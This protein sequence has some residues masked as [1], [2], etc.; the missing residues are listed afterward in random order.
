MFSP[1]ATIFNLVVKSKKL[2]W[3][4]GQS[5]HGK[6]QSVLHLASSSITPIYRFS[7][8]ALSGGRGLNKPG[9]RDPSK[10]AE[11]WLILTQVILSLQLSF[12]VVPLVMFTFV[13]RKM[14]AMRA[15]S[16]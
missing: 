14:G 3:L 6:G 1:D 2:A 15:P 12:A 10:T 16:G 8:P 5:V 11:R 4:S 9:S 7:W 13:A